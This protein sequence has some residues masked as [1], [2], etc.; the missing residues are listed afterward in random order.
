[1]FAPKSSSRLFVI[2]A[3]FIA[4]AAITVSANWGSGF[5]FF[6]VA[7]T[8][9]ADI[10]GPEL[11]VGAS[12]GEQPSLVDPAILDTRTGA[13]GL[14]TIVQYSLGERG[15]R[16]VALWAQVPQYVSGS[17]SPPAVRSIV[18]RLID[19]ARINVELRPL[20]ERCTAYRDKVEEG[21]ADRPDVLAIVDQIDEQ[22]QER[23]PSGDELANEIER[24]LRE[25][26]DQG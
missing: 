23:I 20:D 3:I 13:T 6:K 10:T 2:S 22:W 5:G 8:P 14:N 9:A 26:G 12:I 17:A 11:K 15:I 7:D 21:L 16:S 18:G 1:M 24:F 25:Q 4:I 19:L